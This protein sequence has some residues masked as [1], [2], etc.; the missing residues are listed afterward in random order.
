MTKTC[1]HR[2]IIVDNDNTSVKLL[3]NIFHDYHYKMDNANNEIDAADKIKIKDYDY[4]FISAQIDGA[5]LINLIKDIKQH[6]KIIV[7]VKDTNLETEERIR[8]LGITY[9]L[10]KPFTKK[11]IEELIQ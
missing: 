5:N 9:L 10:K 8:S 4:Y 3:N 1:K 6:S 2:I 11:E 7:M